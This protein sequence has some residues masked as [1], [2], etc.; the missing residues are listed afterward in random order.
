ML[1]GL[2]FLFWMIKNKEMIEK[3]IGKDS[4]GIRLKM[5]DNERITIWELMKGDRVENVDLSV[6]ETKELKKFLDEN[7]K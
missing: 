7:L 5:F 6:K 3:L 4:N 2:D 1:G